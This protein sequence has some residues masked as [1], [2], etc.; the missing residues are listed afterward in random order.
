MDRDP[1]AEPA[2]MEIEVTQDVILIRVLHI[3]V[4]VEEEEE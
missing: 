2:R 3:Q 4:D 1:P